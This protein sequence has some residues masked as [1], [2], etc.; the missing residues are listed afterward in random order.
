MNED[1]A[2][3]SRNHRGNMLQKQQLHADTAYSEREVGNTLTLL[4]FGQSLAATSYWPNL[5]G[6][7][8]ARELGKCSLQWSRS[9]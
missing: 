2:F 1:L 3:D 9:D 5:T 7:P 6:I 4:L 8:L